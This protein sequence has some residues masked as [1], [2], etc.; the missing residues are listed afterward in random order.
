MLSS[1]QDLRDKILTVLKADGIIQ[2]LLG[3]N[4]NN[5]LAIVY[6]MAREVVAIPGITIFDF[7]TRPD[8]AIA[9]FQSRTM[10]VD[11][12]AET[13]AQA[14][15]LAARVDSVLNNAGAFSTQLFVANISLSSDRDNIVPEGFM[16]RKTLTYNIL[17]YDRASTD[18]SLTGAA[19]VD[20]TAAG[21]LTL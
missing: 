17:A 5:D 21:A 3:D 7:G 6:R 15:E 4:V 10:Q 1:I 11:I 13:L 14:E 8:A 16:S 20:A 18:R 2:T 19:E 12:W 9:P